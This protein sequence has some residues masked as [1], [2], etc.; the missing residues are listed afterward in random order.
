MNK[1]E[2]Q[3]KVFT[4]KAIVESKLN[5][6]AKMQLL[7]YVKAANKYEVMALLLDGKIIEVNEYNKDIIV[8]RFSVSKY[9][10]IISNIKK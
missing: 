7:E 3:L 5:K 2:L 8:D 10:G 4:G 6:S 9:P 1:S